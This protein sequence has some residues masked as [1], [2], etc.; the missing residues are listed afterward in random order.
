MQKV[1]VGARSVMTSTD[2]RRQQLNRL[3]PT[4]RHDDL[5]VLDDLVHG[6]SSLQRRTYEFFQ[7]VSVLCYDRVDAFA[8]CLYGAVFFQ[9]FLSFVHIDI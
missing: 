2:T 4:L 9:L 5:E 7:R 6:E 1:F 3:R 8:I